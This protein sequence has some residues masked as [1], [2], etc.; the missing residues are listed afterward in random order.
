MIHRLD[1]EPPQEP[2]QRR[3]HP[4][5]LWESW[6]WWLRWPALIAFLLYFAAAFA[7]PVILIWITGL[8]ILDLVK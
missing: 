4:T 1:F 8:S 7:L 3:T 2:P 6:P 5:N